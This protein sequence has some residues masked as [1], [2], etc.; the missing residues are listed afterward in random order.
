MS[1]SGAP[2]PS[3]LIKGRT[4]AHLSTRAIKGRT[5]MFPPT[6]FPSSNDSS[7]SPPRARNSINGGSRDL[8]NGH[9]KPSLPE[10]KTKTTMNPARPKSSRKKTTGGSSSKTSLKA[11]LLARIQK[12][13]T[14]DYTSCLS[15]NPCI[16]WRRIELFS[17][18]VGS[19]YFLN[20]LQERRNLGRFWL[21]AR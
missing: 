18:D 9:Q 13:L 12:K 3:Y 4:L 1:L 7:R 17:L 2:F 11:K 15:I 21:P 19:L 8:G 20:C 16:L 10:T 14:S 6:Y 5:P